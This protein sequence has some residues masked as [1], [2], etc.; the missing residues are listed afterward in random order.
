MRMGDGILMFLGFQPVSRSGMREY[1]LLDL[2]SLH[3]LI[4]YERV[5]SLSSLSIPI[6]LSKTK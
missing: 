3:L 6:I 1:I 2:G 5:A 4:V